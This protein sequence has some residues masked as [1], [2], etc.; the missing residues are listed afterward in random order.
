MFF[1]D[2]DKSK[3]IGIG[4]GVGVGALAILGAVLVYFWYRRKLNHRNTARE[5]DLAQLSQT[6]H[7]DEKTNGNIHQR[8]GSGSLAY[9]QAAYGPGAGNGHGDMGYAAGGAAYGPIEYQGYDH[10]HVEDNSISYVQPQ[11]SLQRGSFNIPRKPPNA[12]NA[13]GF[14]QPTPP[15]VANNGYSSFDFGAGT[16]SRTNSMGTSGAIHPI[17]EQDEDDHGEITDS[18]LIGIARGEVIPGEAGD[19]FNDSAYPPSQRS[20]GI[21]MG[22]LRLDPQPGLEPPPRSPLR[23]QIPK[24]KLSPSEEKLEK[25]KEVQIGRAHV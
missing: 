4:A 7:W 5:K 3:K 15:V 16:H 25:Q 2:H 19:P 23:D 22:R 11:A 13:R 6:A 20:S 14:Y 8:V 1:N 24:L 17:Y 9:G 10:G 21:S 12:R 18:H